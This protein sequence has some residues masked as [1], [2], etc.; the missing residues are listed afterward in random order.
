[1]SSRN[2][3]ENRKKGDRRG[4][5]A[6]GPRPEDEKRQEYQEQEPTGTKIR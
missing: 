6:Q 5:R 3:L 2:P 4:K 1:M